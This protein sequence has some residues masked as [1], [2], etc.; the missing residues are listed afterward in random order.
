MATQADAGITLTYA[1]DGRGYKLI[2]LPPEVLELLESENP[3][4]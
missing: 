2:E 1:H 4:T 3:P